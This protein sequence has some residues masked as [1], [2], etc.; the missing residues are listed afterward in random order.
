NRAV[1]SIEAPQDKEIAKLGVE[2]NKTYVAYGRAG[3]ES[4][5]RQYRQDA[6]AATLAPA[7][8]PVQRSLAKASA[9]YQN[10]SWDLVDAA[11]AKDFKLSEIKKEELP[12]EMQKMNVEERKSFIEKHAKERA[13]LQ[14]K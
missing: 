13:D 14:E 9:N 7:G 12:A 1:V 3:A 11:K 10:S 6:N 4:A 5:Q 8:A 2:L